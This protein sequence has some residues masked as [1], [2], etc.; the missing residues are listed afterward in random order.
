M[1]TSDRSI[2][3]TSQGTK[4]AKNKKQ[5]RY[6]K[7]TFERN[8][9]HNKYWFLSIL[10]VRLASLSRIPI[11]TWVLFSKGSQLTWPCIRLSLSRW[12]I[13]KCCAS[14]FLLGSLLI[15]PWIRLTNHLRREFL[16][17]LGSLLF[18][19]CAGLSLSPKLTSQCS[20]FDF[21]W[22]LS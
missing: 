3:V 22:D 16:F 7:P 18:W 5:Q 20:E 19:S 1:S 2:S 10:V 13:R 14:L 15:L 11:R 4:W 12:P 17:L 6:C 21:H 9:L 8:A